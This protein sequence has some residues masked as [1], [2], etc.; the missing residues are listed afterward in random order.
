MI[1]QI[2]KLFGSKAG[3]LADPKLISGPYGKTNPIKQIASTVIGAEKGIKK[4][5]Q[6][7]IGVLQSAAGK[8][9][10]KTVDHG[11]EIIGIGDRMSPSIQV[12]GGMVS[13][14]GHDI[15]TKSDRRF[16]GSQI[17][18]LGK[19][20][21]GTDGIVQ[22]A[23]DIVMSAGE[24]ISKQQ[25]KLSKYNR[26][27]GF[28]LGSA[29]VDDVKGYANTAL[30]AGESMF[31]A[32]EKN[33]LGIELSK[34]G[35]LVATGAALI[36]GTSQATKNFNNHTMG[37]QRDSQITPHAPSLPAYANNAGATGDLV[38]ALNANRKG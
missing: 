15:N 4:A 33:L 19:M 1:K 10:Q 23:G 3:K 14:A 5:N 36:S 22:K 11:E 37:T 32:S 8:I 24:G 2:G 20:I 30:R 17:S 9:G 28:D 16:F 21:T 34:R 26:L 38:F 7:S 27:V 25:E 29:I 13:K 6:S 12:L 35:K 18:K 31:R